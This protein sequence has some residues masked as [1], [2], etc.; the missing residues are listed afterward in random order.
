MSEFETVIGLEIHIQLDTASRLFSAEPAG[1]IDGRPNSTSGPYSFGHPG[2]YPVLNGKAVDAAI[3]LGLAFD[4]RINPESGFDRKHYFYPDLPRGYQI[5]QHLVP[6]CEEGVYAPADAPD[7][8]RVR[9][10]S[11][12]LEEDAGR[13]IHYADRTL[14]DYDRAGIPLLELV[15]EPDIRSSGDA[16]DFLRDLR[17]IVRTL[18]IG[19]GRMEDGSIRCDANVSVRTP[20][21]PRGARVEI[22]NMNS[23]R[24][25]EQAI[26]FEADRHADLLDAGREVVGETRRFDSEANTTVPMRSKETAPD[27]R[28]I[29]EPDLP[30]IRVSSE[31]IA[32]AAA[33]LVERPDRRR[34]RLRED[35]GLSGDWARIIASDP[36]AAERLDV[37]RRVLESAGKA[38]EHRSRSLV[39]RVAAILVEEVL[40][41]DRTAPPSGVLVDIAELVE[42]RL[43]SAGAVGELLDAVAASDEGDVDVRRLAEVT[44]I[45]LSH[46]EEVLDACILDVVREHPDEWRRYVGGKDGLLGFFVGRVL[47]ALEEPADPRTVS[48]RVEARRRSSTDSADPDDVAAPPDEDS[49]PGAP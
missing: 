45:L 4:C 22:K 44:G 19:D 29:P 37:A 35:L 18:G 17:D 23:F 48:D 25:V 38:D 5:T 14:V 34:R 16:A 27:Y 6:F 49:A 12:H 42:D 28:F 31:Q 3:R 1:G 46:D 15:T 7:R 47:G 36:G 40:A 43:I 26:S 30:S 41:A 39:R 21:E 8:N 33:A 20:G 2:T 13:L 9:I 11:I 32:D 24:H 10:R